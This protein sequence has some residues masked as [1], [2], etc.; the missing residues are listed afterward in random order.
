MTLNTNDTQL[1]KR[2]SSRENQCLYWTLRGK[3][4]KETGMILNLSRRTVECY[5]HTSRKKLGV[6]KT[7]EAMVLDN[8]LIIQNDFAS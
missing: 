1:F 3:T 7:I 8:K 2:L 4:A 6:K 5:L